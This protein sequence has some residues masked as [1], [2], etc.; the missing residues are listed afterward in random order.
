MVVLASRAGAQAA[1]GYAHGCYVPNTGTVYRILEPNTPTTCRP[2]H[3]E[4]KW[5]K[6][7]LQV[8]SSSAALTV[9]NTGAGSALIATASNTHG[10]IGTTNSAG[11]VAGV[12]GI[13]QQNGVQGVTLN[14][15]V[16]WGVKGSAHGTA[17]G[18]EGLSSNGA[19]IRGNALDCDNN[20]CTPTAGDA[21][22]FVAGVGGTLVH[23]FVNNGTAG[24][25][26]KFR[27]GADGSGLFTGDLVVQGS[28]SKPSGG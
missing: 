15:S 25:V 18:V 11:N 19:G 6:N 17:V 13:G 12:L 16:G 3:V 23:G 9:G 28:A 7:P 10:V 26:E 2:G 4:F 1:D 20:G 27:V 22:Q 24:W 21:G 8:N 14:T 5:V